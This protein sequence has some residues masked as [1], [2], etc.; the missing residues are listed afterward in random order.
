MA[1]LYSARH[2]VRPVGE[3]DPPTS[4]ASPTPGFL[5]GSSI[6]ETDLD[7]FEGSDT[8]P[9]CKRSASVERSATMRCAVLAPATAPG[10]SHP[11]AGGVDDLRL[12]PIVRG[13]FTLRGELMH[14]FVSYRVN[15]EG[16][17][18]TLQQSSAETCTLQLC[19]PLTAPA[20]HRAPLTR[21]DG[22]RAR[23]QRARRAGRRE[24]PVHVD[25]PQTRPPADTAARLGH[26]SE[27]REAAGAVSARGGKGTLPLLNPKRSTRPLCALK[28]VSRRAPRRAVS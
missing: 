17:V 12:L 19:R 15:T 21:P 8:P 13:T 23:G 16:M 1:A 3:D 25:G 2:A 24:D 9:L 11:S 14:C 20:A 5:P 18:L 27:E 6:P 26:L 22:C 10:L 7:A 4:Q 28:Q